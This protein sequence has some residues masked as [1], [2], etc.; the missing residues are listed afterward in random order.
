MSIIPYYIRIGV[1]GHRVL[2]DK[3]KL[4]EKIRE[5]LHAQIF[6]LFDEQ[7][8]EFLRL[9]AHTPVAFSILT[10]LAEGAD[11]LVAYE[12]L[13]LSNARI[14]VALPFSKDDYL[15]DFSSEES[16]R[17]FEEF[18][19]QARRPVVIHPL[20]PS[21]AYAAGDRKEERR[22]AYL[23]VGK[24]VVNHS[25]L[26]I[27]LWDG[28]PWHGKSGT[29]QIVAYAQ[30]L[31]RPL[32]IIY[33][34]PPYSI[35][36]KKGN[37]LTATSIPR[38]ESYLTYPIPE[39]D[40]QSYVENVYAALFHTPQGRL[41]SEESKAII[42]E[43]L[44]PF[45][46]RSSLIAKY[47]QKIYQSA[48]FFVYSSSVFAVAAVS[49]GVLCSAW[50]LYAFFVELILL[51][52]I[53]C[54]VVFADRRRAHTQWIENRFLAERIRCAVF[55]AL[56]GVEVSPIFVPSYLRLAHAPDEWMVRVFHELWN[57]LPLMQGCAG[58]SCMPLVNYIRAAWIQDQIRFHD[59]KAKTSGTNSR[60]LEKSG[61][62]VFFIALAAIF[63]HI[64][65][66][67][68]FRHLQVSF[69]EKILTFVALV[70]PAAGAAIGGIRTH[71]EYSRL[72]KRSCNMAAVL[73]DLDGR[74]AQVIRGDELEALLRETDELMLRET[75]D[76][77]MLMRLVK[78]EAAV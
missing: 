42:R 16:R 9:S 36:V 14:E 15:Q 67:C 54:V 53:L 56:C 7:S 20:S 72:E 55:F 34:I 37:G 2:P 78:L 59:K 26:L 11:R 22:Q 65:L 63:S 43:K 61:R 5:V 1:T 12:V 19:S 51:L 71:R 46:V 49:V 75:Q 44:L 76:W 4:S 24:Y 47:Y 25:D 45:Y 73:S 68:V 32:I 31:N 17:E 41:L 50:S 10:P 29:A 28:Q 30:A 3:E 23:D 27:A 60:R 21:T 40:G 70:L 57:R 64:V 48:G 77:L 69:L 35:S 62:I 38:I 39:K 33:T 6:D 52:A 74:F 13:K 66:L 18:L 8:R 58:A